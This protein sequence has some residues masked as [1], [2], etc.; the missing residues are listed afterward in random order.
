MSVSVSAHGWAFRRGGGGD[1]GVSVCVDVYE[2]LRKRGEHGPTHN[3]RSCGVSTHVGGARLSPR[4]PHHNG[5]WGRPW[6]QLGMHLCD[7][8]GGLRAS[9]G[10][11]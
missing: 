3:A 4:T 8:D 5:P 7:R 11:P 2:C 6:A 9:G 1:V 10:S